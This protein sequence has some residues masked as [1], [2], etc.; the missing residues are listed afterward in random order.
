MAEDDIS[1]SPESAGPEFST[2]GQLSTASLRSSSPT[3]FHCHSLESGV[4]LAGGEGCEGGSG[5]TWR[6]W[7]RHYQG[8]SA[9]ELGEPPMW[10]VARLL[11]RHRV[12]QIDVRPG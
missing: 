4:P 10:G 3:P 1:D 11:D 2:R 9:A 5:L 12:L 8:G 7:W 6:W